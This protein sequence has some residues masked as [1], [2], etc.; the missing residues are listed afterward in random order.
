[1]NDVVT[2]RG[3]VNCKEGRK[4]NISSRSRSDLMVV[5]VDKVERNALSSP[6]YIFVLQNIKM[7]P[8]DKITTR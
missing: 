8:N 3:G 6:M 1:M 7:F 5:R 4:V 2:L